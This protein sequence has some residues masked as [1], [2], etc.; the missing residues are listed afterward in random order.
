MYSL[1]TLILCTLLQ[2]GSEGTVPPRLQDPQRQPIVQPTQT[3]LAPAQ[4]VPTVLPPVVVPP[5]QPNQIFIQNCTLELPRRSRFTLSAPVSAIL[6]SLKTE[7]RDSG[8]NPV[9]VPIT[10]GMTVSKGQVLGNLDDRDLRSLLKIGEAQVEVAKAEKEKKIEVQVAALAL[11]LAMAEFV[12]MQEANKQVIGT[13]SEFELRRAKMAEYHAA[14]NLDLQKYTLEEIKTREVI[15]R[16]SELDRTKDQINLRKLT[17]EIDGIIV[18]IKAAEGEWLREGEPILEIRQLDTMW[19]KVTV[20]AGK[21]TA[22]DLDGKRATVQVPLAN[23]KK[24]SFQG[25]VVFCNPNIEQGNTFWVYIEVQNRRADNYW[26]LQPG[27]AG[28]EIVIPL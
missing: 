9:V 15:V 21:Y 28:V 24:E 18:E 5:A 23:G 20:D 2:V 11:Q 16:E 7:Q 17:A 13:V 1:P 12:S 25:T 19:V 3:P 26:L 10:E 27:R 6:T 14:A 8:G 4:T 22:S